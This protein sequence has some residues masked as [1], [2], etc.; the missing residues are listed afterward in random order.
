MLGGMLD[1]RETAGTERK[2]V[3]DGGETFPG[4]ISHCLLMQSKW[5]KNWPKNWEGRKLP[6]FHRK[7]EIF[8]HLF[9]TARHQQRDEGW[10]RD[11]SHIDRK[12]LEN[13]ILTDWWTQKVIFVIISIMELELDHFEET[14]VVQ[15]C[16]VPYT[17]P[18]INQCDTTYREWCAKGLWSCRQGGV[19]WD[20]WD[21]CNC[22]MSTLHQ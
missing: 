3:Q 22:S 13:M 14:T 17:Q 15:L 7:Q 8:S 16:G 6:S 18:H 10:M 4:G 21:S 12:V 19:G 20:T 1:K 5:I 2:G 9:T 11:A